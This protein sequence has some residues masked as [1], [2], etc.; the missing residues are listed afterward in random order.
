MY[1]S[2]QRRKYEALAASIATNSRSVLFEAY[3]GRSYACSPKALYKEMLADDRFSECEFVWAFREGWVPFDEPDLERAVIVK[4]GSDSYF[5]AL[6][7]AGIIVM[8]NRLP[9]YVVPKDDQVYVQCWHGT[10]LKRLGYDVKIEMESAL[11]TTAEL[12]ERFG[13]DARKWTYL[14]SPSPYASKHLADAFG[15][16]LDRRAGVVVE[17][18]YPRNDAL[19][20]ARDD[21]AVC[22]ELR[23]SLGV[24]EGKRALLYAP[25]WRDDSYEDGVGYTF[26]YLLDFGLMKKRLGDEWVVLFRPHYY[27]ANQFDF[28]AYEGFV[29]D[30]S[31]VD[32]VN[33][34]YLAS[35]LLMTDYSSVMFDYANLRR[36][37]ILFAPDRDRYADAIRGFYFS[38]EEVP[39]PLCMTT[40]EV[41]EKVTHVEEHG[42]QYEQAY[43]AF[44][45]KFCPL[46]DGFASAR[47]LERLASLCSFE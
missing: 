43:T 25:T 3:G 46:D 17:E 27:V 4:R 10:P 45:E 9:E 6:A 1:W 28:S 30:V 47:V 8:N 38:L 20:R 7:R 11:N 32:D 5:K 33:D 26:D 22:G 2:M 35:D 24:P 13:M 41:V 23:R 16:S 39:G 14:L 36:P 29:I 37:I 12:A 15:L 31:K 44:V 42:L 21:R 40:D 18:G 19:V 34:L